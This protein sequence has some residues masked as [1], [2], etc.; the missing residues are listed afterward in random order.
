MPV[1]QHFTKTLDRVVDED[2]RLPTDAELDAIEAFTLSL[3]RQDE[4]NFETMQLTDSNAEQGRVLF[5]TE[6]S[7][8]QTVQA[9]KM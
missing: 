9:A 2:F 5:I 8:N 6:D 1:T 4:M 7:Q 3:G